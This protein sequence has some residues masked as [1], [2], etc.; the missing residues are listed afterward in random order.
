MSETTATTAAIAFWVGVM[1]FGQGI[2][3]LLVNVWLASAVMAISATSAVL[4]L[5]G[6]DNQNGG[7]G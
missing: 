1:A 2:A 6:E 4:A 7:S 5:R 3:L